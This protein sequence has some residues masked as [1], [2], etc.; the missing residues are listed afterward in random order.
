[1]SLQETKAIYLGHPSYVWRFGQERRLALIQKYAPLE[2]KRILDVGCGLGVYTHR[3][4]LFSD[5]VYGVDL[6]VEKAVQARS[7]LPSICVAPAEALPFPDDCFDLV[8]LHEVLEHVEDDRK[9]VVEAFRCT[10]L[11]GKIVVFAPNRLY[12]FETHGAYFGGRYVF[13][14]IPLINYL[15]NLLRQ[16]LC[17]HV[18][19]Y[20]SRSIRRLFGGLS[21]HFIFH[22][23][24][25]PGY[26]NIAQRSPQLAALARQI[27][28][29]LEKTPL[30]AFGLSHFLVMQKTSS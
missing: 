3:L 8:L 18:R 29:A 28:Y 9:T 13:G 6:D 17:P 16:R 11:G 2:G 20:T 19:A 30:R 23:Q 27:T 7:T 5:Q 22:T 12:P 24:I 4:C 14:L 21:G 10:K 25:F 15:P 26:D 1:M